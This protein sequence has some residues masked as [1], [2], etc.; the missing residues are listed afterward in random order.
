MSGFPRKIQVGD[1]IDS[2]PADTWNW[3]VESVGKLN[4]RLNRGDIV[5]PVKHTVPHRMP[6]LVRNDTSSTVERFQAIGLKDPLP[7]LKDSEAARQSPITFEGVRPTDKTPLAIYTADC[8]AGKL[9]PAVII[10]L[11]VAK[12]DV[13][14]EDDLNCGVQSSG[15]L[16]SGTGAIKILWKEKSTLTTG[17]KLGEQY[18]A[19]LLGSGGGS[20]SPTAVN[21]FIATASFNGRQIFRFA[22]LPADIRA[23]LTEGG[24]GGPAGG[25]GGAPIEIEPPDGEPPPS[26]DI[27][28]NTLVHYFAPA[29]GVYLKVINVAGDVVPGSTTPGPGYY[30]IEQPGKKYQL[31]NPF[32]GGASADILLQ[33][34]GAIITGG[35]C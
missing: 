5:P 9:R 3:L 19:V 33:A 24:G 28:D 6:V 25:G 31:H 4:A 14:A 29:E 18:C 35:D 15:K 34:N 22:D 20:S 11:V 7:D 23:K 12:V 26:T 17:S 13:K 8:P 10:G 2:F 21:H 1:T 32:T 30:G 16:E 27:T